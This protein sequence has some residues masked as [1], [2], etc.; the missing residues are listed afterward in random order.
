ME[1]QQKVSKLHMCVH[2]LTC[3]LVCPMSTVKS[4]PESIS[5]RMSFSVCNFFESKIFAS[6]IIHIHN[7]IRYNTE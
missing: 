2:S 4:D 5:F 1:D 7:K 3:L 6:Q